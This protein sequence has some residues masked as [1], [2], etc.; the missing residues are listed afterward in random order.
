MKDRNSVFDLDHL[1]KVSLGR[2]KSADGL[3]AIGVDKERRIDLMREITVDK[4]S[5][6]T[7]ALY[8]RGCARGC[9]TY[10]NKGQ[11][12]NVDVDWR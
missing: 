5:A 8:Y 3:M 6:I 4:C 7:R 9:L 11:R 12:V 1:A 10:M 2:Q